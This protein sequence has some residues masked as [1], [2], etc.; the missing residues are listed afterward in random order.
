MSTTHY[1]WGFPAASIQPPTVLL[2][3]SASSGYAPVDLVLTASPS[4]P[5][6][7]VA[8]VA[9][10]TVSA[11]AT[12]LVTLIGTVT[13]APYTLAYNAA[14]GNY[15]FRATVQNGAGTTAN[16]ALL[17]VAFTA[18][19][20]INV[21]LQTTPGLRYVRVTFQ[22]R[23]KQ[24]GY[25]TANQG[26]AYGYFQTPVYD[27]QN[28]FIGFATTGDDITAY[29]DSLTNA[30]AIG[31]SSVFRV[32]PTVAG[33]TTGGI[34]INYQLKS[35][36]RPNG[37]GAFA[38]SSGS[39]FDGTQTI[40]TLTQ[41]PIRGLAVDT[42]ARTATFNLNVDAVPGTYEFQAPGTTGYVSV[43][44][45]PFAI[46]DLAGTLSVRR[47]ATAVN[48]FGNQVNASVAAASAPPTISN[49]TAT[50]Q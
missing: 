26:G 21:N 9:F 18:A 37:L 4:A 34:A 1:Y 22:D 27:A 31:A 50:P 16:S 42:T 43:P 30:Q 15:G 7:T 29:L 33:N 48:P 2:S 46:G 44:A 45:L 28:V 36:G 35:P 40:P 10:Y 5:G 38:V 39:P 20:I 32:E 23:F 47:K 6:S 3:A 24:I 19:P 49:F 11:D 12:P 17:N 13:Q 14:A 8:S 41:P 25:A